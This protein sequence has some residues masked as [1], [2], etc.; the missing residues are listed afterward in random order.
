MENQIGEIKAISEKKR[1]VLID[2]AWLDV[3]DNIKMNFINKGKCEYKLN[4]QNEIVFIKNL[5]K[6]SNKTWEDEIVSFETLLN[7]AHEEG[8]Q[9]ITT[10]KLGINLEK[11]YALFKAV[12]EGKKGRFEAHGDATSEN[13]SGDFIKPHFI[14]MAETRAIARALRW[15]TNN[16]KVSKEEI[17]GAI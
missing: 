3:A 13:V 16:A 11:K 7:K 10:E 15:Y 8:L 5:D 9:S 6:S 1:G 2:E 14:R 12:A 17:E 4:D